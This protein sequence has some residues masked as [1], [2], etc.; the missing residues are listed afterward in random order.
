MHNL[1]LSLS[2][3]TPAFN[4][5]MNIFII[6]VYTTLSMFLKKFEIKRVY[7]IQV[8]PSTN[9]SLY[10]IIKHSV[11]HL[12]KKKILIILEVNTEE[13]LSYFKVQNLVKKKMETVVLN[14][15]SKKNE[16]SRDFAS[17]QISVPCCVI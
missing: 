3:K 16:S 12:K 13:Q 4:S 7:I 5:S 9:I 1:K 17:Y 11:I 8:Q 15:R 14:A 6:G 2:L 10:R